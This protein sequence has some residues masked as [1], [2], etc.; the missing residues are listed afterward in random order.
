[1]VEP[2]ERRKPSPKT[3]PYADIQIELTEVTY[4]KLITT[5]SLGGLGMVGT[6][7]LLAHR[8]AEPLL[9]SMAGLMLV[10]ASA[11]VLLALAFS[12]RGEGS[13]TLREAY[14]WQGW[15]AVTT[16]VY[17][18][19]LAFTTIYIFRDHGETARTLAMLGTFAVSA[20]LNARVGMRPRFTNIC[21][22]VLLGSMMFSMLLRDDGLVRVGALIPLL[23]SISQL[24]AA[25]NKF[26]ILV[27]QIRLKKQFRE[28]AELD[29]LTGLANRRQFQ[30][31]LA[32]V[33]DGQTSFAINDD[34]G[35][36]AGDLLL[37]LVAQRLRGAVR[38]KDLVA[39]LGGDEFAILQ[40]PLSTR[41]ST[42]ALAQRIVE[43]LAEPF[44]IDGHPVRIGASVGVHLSLEGHTDSTRLMNTADAAL[45]RVKQAGGGSFQFA[46]P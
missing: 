25:Q 28:L 22:I 37:Q 2:T 35:H 17:C 39:R 31:R 42:E 20:G 12:M 13:L 5:V 4:R 6:V 10:A 11:R 40:A 3:D 1:M 8:Y 34:L 26:E 24:E 21:S 45:Y 16:L 18:G 43:R 19:L 46:E 23:L 41:E 9:W 33:C 14:R 30:T 44:D 32:A 29:T 15:Y 38:T 7:A 36:A 27:E